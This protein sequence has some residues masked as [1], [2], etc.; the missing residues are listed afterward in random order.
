LQIGCGIEKKLTKSFDYI[1]LSAEQGYSKAINHLLAFIQKE[2]LF[3]KINSN[4][5]NYIK[6]QLI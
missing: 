2:R 4:Q 6:Q 3:Q 1:S 5:L